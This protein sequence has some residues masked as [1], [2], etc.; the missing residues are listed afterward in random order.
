MKPHTFSLQGDAM[1]G[2]QED[3]ADGLDR[4]KRWLANARVKASVAANGANPLAAPI[5]DRFDSGPPRFTA[6]VTQ[7]HQQDAQK[8]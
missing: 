3:R 6:E 8:D 1:T 2:S 4:A 5:A 7:Q